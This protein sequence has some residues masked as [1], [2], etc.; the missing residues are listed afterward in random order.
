MLHLNGYTCFCRLYLLII[1]TI[2]RIKYNDQIFWLNLPI[3]SKTRK[4]NDRMT[5][6][7]LDASYEFTSGRK[8]EISL[9]RDIMLRKRAVVQAGQETRYGLNQWKAVWHWTIVSLLNWNPR[10]LVGPLLS[11]DARNMLKTTDI[12]RDVRLPRSGRYDL[13]PPAKFP[14]TRATWVFRSL[15]WRFGTSQRRRSSLCKFLNM[16]ANV[17]AS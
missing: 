9:T 10:S 12:A 5:P 15:A 2:K 17:S 1:I 6:R 3:D 14:R 7:R 4:I 16:F 11:Q 8:C 13:I